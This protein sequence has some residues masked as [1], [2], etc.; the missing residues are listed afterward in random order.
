MI[1]NTYSILFQYFHVWNNFFPQ[2]LQI[3]R[4]RA[5]RVYEVGRFLS[6]TIF[7]FFNKI[8]ATNLL[9]KK[10]NSFSTKALHLG[11]EFIPIH[12]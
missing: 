7:S 11:C 9:E 3:Q 6:T 12:S 2:K 1:E 8:L 5:Q 4:I 10:G